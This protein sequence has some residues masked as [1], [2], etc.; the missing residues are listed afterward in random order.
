[1]AQRATVQADL[2]RASAQ[3]GGAF[4]YLEAAI[5]ECW[6]EAKGS[7]AI[8]A[9]GRANLRLACAHA[10]EISA[11][12]CKTAYTLGGGSAVYSTS[13]LQRR[14]RDAHVATQHI[15]TAPA[16]FE[17]AG[18]ILLEQPVDMVML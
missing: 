3:L 16:V 8:S 2:A 13:S 6:A 14:F 18:R 15:A 4:A 10:T 1:M 11:E 7:G 17:L 5:S 9:K 12:V